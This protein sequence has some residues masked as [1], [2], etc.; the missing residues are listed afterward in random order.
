MDAPPA[1]PAASTVPTAASSDLEALSIH[2]RARRHPRSRI[3]VEPI[4]WTKLQLELLRCTFQ[5]VS[6]A[7]PDAM[8]LRFP[9]D[10][11]RLEKLGHRLR[12]DFVDREDAIQRLIVTAQGPLQYLYV[13]KLHKRLSLC[14]TASGV[15]I[16]S[17]SDWEDIAMSYSVVRITVCGMNL[18]VA[19]CQCR[20]WLPMSTMAALFVAGK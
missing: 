14:L 4:L 10:A 8:R 11:L 16:T 15:A 18:W 19:A 9:D 13:A 1:K 20:R 2:D 3:L 5:D 7:P 17:L 12:G 6:P